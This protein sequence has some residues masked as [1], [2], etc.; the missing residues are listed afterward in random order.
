MSSVKVMSHPTPSPSVNAQVILDGTNG[1]SRLFRTATLVLSNGSHGGFSR[2]RQLAASRPHLIDPGRFAQGY[3]NKACI[4]CPTKGFTVHVDLYRSVVKDETETTP[5]R[6]ATA[7]QHA[8]SWDTISSLE[9][10]VCAC[11]VTISLFI[12]AVPTSRTSVAP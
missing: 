12:R 1:L 8:I 11:Q 2:Q 4:T 5:Y 9:L 10:T 3:I 7:V 6:R